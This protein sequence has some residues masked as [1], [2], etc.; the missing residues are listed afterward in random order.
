MAAGNGWEARQIDIS[1]AYLQG[2]LVDKHGKQ[3]YIYVDDPLH[4]VCPK[5]G[6]KAIL[7]LKKPL[8][9]LKQ[10]GRRW[11]EEL[12]THLFAH[13]FKRMPTDKCLFTAKVPRRQLD[14]S[15]Q[16]DAVELIVI[17]TS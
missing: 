5:T 10:S 7:R 13:G 1:N 4:R 3:K 9:G 11:Q 15:Y 8:Y 12:H 2:R 16:G 14:P 17:G 6:R